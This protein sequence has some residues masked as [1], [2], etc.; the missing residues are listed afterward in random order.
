MLPF[1][2]DIIAPLLSALQ[3]PAVVEIGSEHGKLT[4]KLCELVAR[5]E[6][7]VH[8]IDPAPLFD[9]DVWTKDL[10]P[11]L[12]V[13]RAKSLDALPAVDGFDVVLVD[14]D[15]NWFTVLSELRLVERLARERGAAHPLVLLHDVTWPYGRRDLYYDPESIPEQHRQSWARRGI[16][17]VSSDLLPRGGLNAHLANATHEGGPRNGVLT[18]VDDYLKE[19]QVE[20]T[21]TIVPAAFGLAIL[22]PAALAAEKPAAL[23]LVRPWMS[24]A[25]RGFL[26]KMETARIAMLTQTS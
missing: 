9:A 24:T 1:F 11:T 12:I 2:A 21:L 18:A 20:Q 26:E 10:A 8:A 25:V 22:L 6:G 19:T 23:E 3:P 15:H 14:G 5:W 17:P 7:R 13:H 4:R 16:S